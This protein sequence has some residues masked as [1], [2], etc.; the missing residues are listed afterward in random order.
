MDLSPHLYGLSEEEF[1]HVVSTF[2]LV[3]QAVKD[4]TLN[5]YRNFALAPSDLALA[6]MIAGGE[7][8]NLEF[9]VASCWNAAQNKKDDKMKYNIVEEV[10]AFLNSRTSGTL[11]I[12]VKDDG[13]VVGLTDDYKAANPQKQNRDGYRLFLID[14]LA[15]NLTGNWNLFCNISFGIL[16]GKEVCIIKVDPAS[17]AIYAKSG[18]FYLRLDTQARRLSPQQAVGYIRER[19]QS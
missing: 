4:A 10:A 9:K 8:D 17:E 14:V 5:A 7:T 15:N 6:A 18:D 1:T 11:L 12:G 19:W 2:P 16:D 3:E 13:T